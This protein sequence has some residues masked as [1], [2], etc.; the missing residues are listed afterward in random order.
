[1]ARFDY[2]QLADQLMD[3]G[4]DASPADLHGCLCGLLAAGADGQAEAG[5]DGLNQALEIDIYGELSEQAMALYV[6]SHVALNSEEFDFYPLLPGDDTDIAVRVAALADWCRSFLRGYGHASS[7][8]SGRGNPGGDAA[9]ILEDL[10]AIAEVD[11]EELEQ[12]EE[13]EQ[14]FMELSEYIRFAALNIYSEVLAPHTD[15]PSSR[16]DNTPLH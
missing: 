10:A 8:G 12:D 6:A 15:D 9:E 5:V 2:G 7:A 1:V 14:N 3:Q 11:L 13:S 4:L 16:P